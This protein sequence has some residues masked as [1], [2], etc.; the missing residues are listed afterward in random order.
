M[1]ALLSLLTAVDE[2][3]GALYFPAR[4]GAKR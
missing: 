1:A 3:L 2:G 4:T